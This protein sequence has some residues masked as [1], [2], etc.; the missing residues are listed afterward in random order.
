MIGSDKDIE[1]MYWMQG[2]LMWGLSNLTTNSEG[3]M[4]ENERT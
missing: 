4:G 3:W 1:S 2:S